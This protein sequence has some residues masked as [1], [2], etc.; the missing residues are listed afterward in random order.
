MLVFVFLLAVLATFIRSV[1]SLY[2]HCPSARCAYAANLVGKDINIS[3]NG[4]VSLDH[5]V[6]W[7]SIA[8]QR[9]QHTHGPTRNNGKKGLYN[10]LLDDDSVTT[11]PRMR[12][13]VTPSIA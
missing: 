6:T 8:R 13:D 11:F 12:N 9:P 5:I 1:L 2:K 4:A 7:K 10:P 3:A